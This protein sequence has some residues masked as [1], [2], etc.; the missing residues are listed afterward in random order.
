MT[1][2]QWV[3]LGFAV[4][5]LIVLSGPVGIYRWW[6]ILNGQSR[7]SEWRA[8]GL[9]GSEWY[10]RAMR[11]HLNCVENLPVYAAIVL[12]ATAAQTTSPLMDAT[13]LTLLAAR[14]C[15][16]TTH[17]AFQQTDR[18]ASVRFAFFFVQIL[19]MFFMGASVAMSAAG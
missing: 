7:V 15:Q 3:L 19:C 9:Q 5:T 1:I 18:V 8:D 13:A 11:A 14:I 17:I 16:T 10:G 6:S 2:P 12:C 4:W